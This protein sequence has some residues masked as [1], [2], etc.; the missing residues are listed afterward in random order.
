MPQIESFPIETKELSTT[1]TVTAAALPAGGSFLVFDPSEA[2][3]INRLKQMTRTE[4]VTLLVAELTG[5]FATAE[6]GELAD[7]SLQPSDIGPSL[8]GAL[9]SVEVPVSFNNQAIARYGRTVRVQTANYTLTNADGGAVIYLESVLDLTLTI[10]D[11]LAPG[12]F[13]DVIQLGGGQ[14][15]WAVSGVAI[16][17]AADGHTQFAAGELRRITILPTPTAN[18]YLITGDTAP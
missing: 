16:A 17:E 6:Q 10:P 12:F 13:C 4:L 9:A 15:Q 7:T 5:A 18:Q 3:I 1:A 2:E 14:H 8:Q 11:G